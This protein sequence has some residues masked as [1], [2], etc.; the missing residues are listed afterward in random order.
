MGYHHIIISSYHH[1][2][3]SSYHHI[4][5]SYH[6]FG[7]FSS[8]LWNRSSEC[9][10]IE[11]AL[12]P[13]VRMRLD[14]AGFGTARQNASRSSWRWNRSSECEFFLRK[15]VFFI[16]KNVFF[17]TKNVFFITKNYPP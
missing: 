8:W 11:L 5:I 4:I 10:S 3:I 2:I 12:E 16:T 15:N 9:V 1:I 17:I 6:H 14:R 13:L 7:P